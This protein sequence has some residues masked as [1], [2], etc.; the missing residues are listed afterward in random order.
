MAVRLSALRAILRLPP[1]RFLVLI[2]VRGRVDPRAIVRLEGLGQLKK[3]NDLT[4]NQTRDL[5]ACNVMPQP[6]T[7]PRA[8]SQKTEVFKC[9]DCTSISPQPFPPEFFQIPC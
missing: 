8:P 1:E 2:S 7:L 4:G 3:S 5:S 9:C 6:T